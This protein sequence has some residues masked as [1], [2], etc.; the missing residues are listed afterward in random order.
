[1]TPTPK[2]TIDDLFAPLDLAVFERLPGGSFQAVG[3]LP[4]WLQTPVWMKPGPVDLTGEFP[5]LEIFLPEFETVWEA[6]S[7]QQVQSDVWTEAD[8]RGGELY[9]QAVAASAGGRHFIALRSLPQALFTYQQLAHDFELEKEKVERLSR[10][11]EVK[12]REAERATQA[13]SD[14]LATMSHEFR[15][16]MNA[17]IGMA[18]V[19]ALTPLST[20]QKKYV[21]IFQRS[22]VSLLNLINEILDLSKVEAGHIELESIDMDLREVLARAMEVVEVRTT[23]KGLWLRQSIAPGVPHYLVGDPNRLRQVMI[24]LLGNSI[25]FTE[26]GGLDIKVEPDPENSAPGRLRFGITDT[27]IG[28]PADKLTLIFESFT[29]VDSSTTRKYGGTGLGLTISKQLV[30]LMGGRIWV[31]SQVGV[32]ST[33][34]FTAQFQVQEDQSERSV[35]Q[36]TQDAQASI[37][38]LEA[39]SAGL[40]ILLVDDSEAN[41][42]LILQY[43]KQIQSTI[44]I[45]ENGQIGVDRFRSGNYDVVLMDCEMPVMDGYEAVGEIRRIEKETGAA[46]TPVL[47]LT[48]H[49]FANMKVKGYEAGFT[50]LLTKPIRR[51]TLLEALAKFGGVKGDRPLIAAPVPIPAETPE[52]DSLRVLVEEGMEDIV[53]GYLEKRRAEVAIYRASL[54]AGDFDAIKKLAHKMKGTGTGY[55]FPKLTELGSRLEAAAIQS[56]A[57]AL[58]E[59]LDQFEFY[60]DR[61]ELQYPA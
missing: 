35:T 19:L 39:L 25:K 49:A 33:F 24:N 58:K 36:H 56:D 22:G 18:D 26:R 46:P 47:A 2:K 5:I 43:M 48:A 23:A 51:V 16:P 3:R 11:L 40:R 37:A 10:E 4:D 29:Q 8:H 57:A 21:E 15:T 61:V 31:E 27:G 30:E 6:G 28:I 17:I 44:D 20:E 50:E 12:R 13:K 41:R 34:Y 1:M 38:E 59:S 55:G 53:P 32:G 45:A 9:L 52:P 7:P 42:I 60:V 54:N 14:F